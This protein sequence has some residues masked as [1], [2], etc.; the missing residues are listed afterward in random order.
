MNFSPR[1]A[2]LA[3]LLTLVACSGPELSRAGDEPTDLRPFVDET[4]LP[5]MEEFDIPGVAVAVTVGGRAHFFTYG[6]A[7]RENGT[8]VTEET[9][10]EMGSVAKTFTATLAGYAAALGD[11]SLDDH[12][13]DHLPPL[14][15][16]AI[17]E[18]TLL[19]LGTYTAGGLPLQFPGDVSDDDEMMEYFRQWDP[20]DEPGAQRRYSN[21]S[22]GLLGRITGLALGGDFSEAMESRL[23]P[24]LRLNDTYIRV[25]ESAMA[26][27][28]WGY[29]AANE[30]VRVNPGVLDAEAYG[31]KSTAREMIRFVEANL[32]PE[33]FSD[34]VR[35]AISATHAGHF[36][37]EGMVQGLGWEQHPYPIPLERLLAGN[38]PTILFGS[39]GAAPILPPRV[40]TNPTLFNKTGSTN[41]FGTYVAFVP[42]ERIG[43]VILANRSF[44]IPARI[45]AAHAILER[46]A[47]RMAST[48]PSSTHEPE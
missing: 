37:V 40:P 16:T 12:P 48:P 47:P 3:A 41:G 8:P 26:R 29:N 15:G 45:T 18:G 25:P 42:Q 14:R 24:E 30:P 28:A 20:E 10:F 34:L 5:L 32:D 44:P 19:H 39:N 6:V 46:L 35:Q 2:A 17:D 31:I 11:L 43:I 4:I 9:I 36:E 27:Y 21:P 13:G 33:P 38:S 23:L 7:D 1:F 22:I